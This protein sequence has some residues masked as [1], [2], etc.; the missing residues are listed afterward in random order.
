MMQSMHHMCRNQERIIGTLMS[1]GSQRFRRDNSFSVEELDDEVHSQEGRGALQIFRSPS[2]QRLSLSQHIRDRRASAPPEE[3]RVAPPERPRRASAPPEQPRVEA[4]QAPAEETEVP[5][6]ETGGAKVD[7]QGQV[8]RLLAAFGVMPRSPA[9]KRPAGAKPSP[10]LKRPAGAKATV[11]KPSPALKLPAGAKEQDFTFHV[12]FEASRSQFLCCF[13]R[14]APEGCSKFKVFRF[15]K[16]ASF[17]TKE[18]ARIAADA[19]G[20]KHTRKLG[21]R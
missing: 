9:L 14:G 21:S 7:D 11:T 13:L 18:A 12:R 20:K 5:A 1:S 10:A 15:G 6:E 2:A 4:P 17:R 8:Q 19:H 16:G 3:P